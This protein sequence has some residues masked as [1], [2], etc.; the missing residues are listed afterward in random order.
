MDT[1]CSG[2]SNIQGSTNS[3]P[4]SDL[5][6]GKSTFPRLKMSRSVGKV[7]HDG[8]ELYRLLKKCQ[9]QLSQQVSE[10]SQSTWVQEAATECPGLMEAGIFWISPDQLI[11]ILVFHPAKGPSMLLRTSRFSTAIFVHKQVYPTIPGPKLEKK[12]LGLG[13]D[14]FRVN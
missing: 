2:F 9:G 12:I 7:S 6:A 1:R 14:S 8:W 5:Q 13:G 4:L 10:K 3:P 11:S